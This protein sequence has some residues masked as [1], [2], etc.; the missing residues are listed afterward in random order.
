MEAYQ[1]LAEETQQHT[2]EAVDLTTAAWDDDPFVA[3]PVEDLLR[4][5]TD[6]FP[7]ICPVHLDKL[8]Q[9]KFHVPES[10]INAIIHELENGVSY[11]KRS[12]LGKRKRQSDPILET[13]AKSDDEFNESDVKRLDEYFMG[14]LWKEEIAKVKGYRKLWYV[15]AKTS[16]N[17]A[18]HI[19]LVPEPVGALL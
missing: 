19:S 18:A 9:E 15:R 8:A 12:V 10:I 2:S 16:Q 14:P 1:Y 6:V 7:D 3:L 11:P 4:Q 13:L 5:V 17:C